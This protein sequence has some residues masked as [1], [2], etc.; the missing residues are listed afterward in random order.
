MSL[1]GFKASKGFLGFWFVHALGDAKS[2]GESDTAAD[3]K[4]R[5]CTTRDGAEA[6]NY[7][8]CPSPSATDLSKPAASLDLYFTPVQ[9]AAE[10][11]RRGVLRAS[12]PAAPGRR[13][14]R[15]PGGRLPHSQPPLGSREL[16]YI[17]FTSKDGTSIL[18]LVFKG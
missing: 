4:A 16:L 3:P 1:L 12:G 15:A 14:R 18:A 11:R 9:P 5:S 7:A 17:R 8:E 2:K 10:H 13:R 6:V